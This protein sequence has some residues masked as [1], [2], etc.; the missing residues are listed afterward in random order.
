MLLTE[1]TLNRK[2]HLASQPTPINP[3]RY[4]GTV[5]YILKTEVQDDWLNMDLLYWYLVLSD[6][7]SVRVYCS[8]Q[9][10]GEIEINPWGIKPTNLNKCTVVCSPW[11]LA[12][13]ADVWS[14]L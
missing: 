11:R 3:L 1:R 13:L 7:N 5:A 6:L 10:A 12:V 14:P 8:V 4:Y 2:K 9:G